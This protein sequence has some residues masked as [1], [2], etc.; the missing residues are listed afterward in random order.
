MK[1][2]LITGGAGYIGSHIALALLDRERE[3]VVV[4][5]LVNGSLQ[6]LASV[7]AITGKKI[8]FYPGDICS[9]ADLD[10]L[11][12]RH[13]IGEAI[14]MAGTES[15]SESLSRPDIYYQNNVTVFRSLTGTAG[16]WQ[17]ERCLEKTVANAWR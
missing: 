8:Y 3:V 1:K 12:R 9:T 6:A 17:T 14:H 7:E 5:N 10:T 13:Q 2:V 4:D 16:T 15:V 11:F